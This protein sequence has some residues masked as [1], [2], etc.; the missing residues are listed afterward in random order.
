MMLV[1]ILVKMQLQEYIIQIRKSRYSFLVIQL[2]QILIREDAEMRE[3]CKNPSYKIQHC[4]SEHT[5]HLMAAEWVTGKRS[6]WDFSAFLPQ[7][8]LSLIVFD[9]K[10][11]FLDSLHM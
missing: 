5:G 7:I 10:D 1:Q 11:V 6:L 4:Q 3:L 9:F 8:S 2:F